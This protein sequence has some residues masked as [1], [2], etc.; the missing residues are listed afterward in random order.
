ME[1]VMVTS[2]IAGHGSGDAPEAA[3]RGLALTAAGLVREHLGID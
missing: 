2:R 3:R 1:D